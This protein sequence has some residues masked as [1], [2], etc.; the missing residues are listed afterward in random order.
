MERFGS[1]F[2]WLLAAA[3]CWL[4]ICSGAVPGVEHDGSF[5]AALESIRSEQLAEHVEYLADDALEGREA[6]SRGSR[7]GG[8]YLA[9]RL[10]ELGLAGAG[11]DGGFFQPFEPNFRNVLG[12]LEGSSPE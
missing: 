9:A 6:G 10:E 3:V 1:A 7:E 2:R 8:E 11:V 4:G 12:L 5:T